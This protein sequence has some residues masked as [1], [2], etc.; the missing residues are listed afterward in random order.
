VLE[1]ELDF[2]AEQIARAPD[3]ESAWN[4]LW[5]LFTLPGC[6]PVD[7]ARQQKVRASGGVG[8][9]LCCGV[10]GCS[11]Q[12]MHLRRCCCSMFCIYPAQASKMRAWSCFRTAQKA[13]S[14]LETTCGASSH[15]QAARLLTWQGSKRCATGVAGYHVLQAMLRWVRGCVWLE[16][17]YMRT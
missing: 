15:C 14:Q 9:R 1:S 7:M 4:Y 11:W 17:Q 16:V 8:C 10:L 2:L 3:N 6:A 12:F 5:G 13:M